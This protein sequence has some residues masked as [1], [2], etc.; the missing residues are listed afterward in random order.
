MENQRRSIKLE[1]YSIKLSR[2]SEEDGGGWLAEVPELEGC[3]TDGETPEE[4]LINIQDAI[5]DWLEVAK[6]NNKPIPSPELY[7]H[8][9]YSGKF[10]LRVPRSLHRFLS[11]Q[12]EAEGISLNQLILTLLTINSTLQYAI[13]NNANQSI[14][15]RTAPK[16]LDKIN[17]NIY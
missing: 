6:E 5:E 15:E 17:Y 2:L 12:A 8:Q 14:T 7:K 1:D 11:M 9:D 4:A 13:N 3:K 10:T 16:Q